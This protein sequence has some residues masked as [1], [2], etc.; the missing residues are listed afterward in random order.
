M[1]VH[2]LLN[3]PL[4]VNCIYTSGQHTGTAY[5]C[6]VT[7]VF[8]AKTILALSRLIPL[9]LSRDFPDFKTYFIDIEE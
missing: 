1:T 2:L 6:D 7:N 3:I 9:S 8:C 5:H 4:Y